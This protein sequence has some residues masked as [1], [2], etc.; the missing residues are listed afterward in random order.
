MGRISSHA[1]FHPRG[2][3]RLV[4][5]RPV[6]LYRARLSW[7][8]GHRF[9]LLTHRGRRTGTVHETMLEVLQYDPGS[10]ES[11]VL[12]GLG[13]RAD[14]YRNIASQ[15]ALAVQTGRLRYTPEHRVLTRVEAATVAAAWER[16]HPWEARLVAPVLKRL[17]WSAGDPA[18]RRGLPADAVLVAFRP[19]RP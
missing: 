4:F 5:R 13:T 1:G 11:I 6:L 15:P 3:L 9:L 7:L 19:R 2:L 8:L 10:R 17:G 16:A 12:S 18:A 14:W